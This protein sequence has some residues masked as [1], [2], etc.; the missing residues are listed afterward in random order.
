[1]KKFFTHINNGL[2]SVAFKVRGR[3]YR[4]SV[5]EYCSVSYSWVVD[6]II[7]LPVLFYNS[8]AV[9]RLAINPP[10]KT[11]QDNEADCLF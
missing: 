7:I 6:V 4:L 10:E 11:S 9:V 2:T 8:F 1:M 5:T 3:N